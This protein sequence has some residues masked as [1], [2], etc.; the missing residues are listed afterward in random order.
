MSPF[1]TNYLRYEE[2]TRIVQDWAKANPGVVRVKSIGKSV[3]GRD[4]LLLEIGSDPDK[5]RAAA[6]VK[7]RLDRAGCTR[8]E[9][10]DTKR[11][12]I[13]YGEW[14]KARDVQ[15]HHEDRGRNRKVHQDPRHANRCGGIRY[16]CGQRLQPG[17]E[18]RRILVP[19][20]I[21]FC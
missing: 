16:R 9:I 3:E 8:T 11:H 7:A 6:W 19:G 15:W 18:Q 10:F 20:L 12:P 14:L 5:K 17:F 13:V 21:L 2:I 4:L 1:R